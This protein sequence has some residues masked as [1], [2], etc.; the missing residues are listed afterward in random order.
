M[1]RKSC[2]MSAHSVADLLFVIALF[3]HLGGQER[4]LL[5]TIHLHEFLSGLWDRLVPLLLLSQV[6]VEILQLEV[7]LKEILHI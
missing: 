3:V 4:W 6:V 7:L 5:Y 2:V 1:C